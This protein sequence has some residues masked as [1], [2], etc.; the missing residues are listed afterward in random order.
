MPIDS[1]I[2]MGVKPLELPDP[3]NAM[4]RVLQVQ[5][6]QGQN[7]LSRYSLA[8]AQRADDET[9]RLAQLL[10]GGGV[11]LSTPEGQAKAFQTAPTVAPGMI[12][13]FM[14][15]KKMT[16][17]IGKNTAQA[18]EFDAKATDAALG[19]F[20]SQLANV[21][22]PQQAAQWVQAQYAH[23]LVGKVMQ[24]LGPLDQAIARIPSDPAQ[25]ETWK[26]QNALGMAKFIELNAPK[27]NVVNTGAAQNIVQTPGLGGAPTI[28]GSLPNTVSPD[29]KLRADTSIQTTGMANATSRANNRDTI[30]S[31]NL[32]MGV[33]PGG[34]L[35]DNAERTAQAIA[36][37]QLPA[38]TGMALL[39]PKNQRILGRVMEINPQYDA[40]TVSAKK[41]AAS[42][43]TSGT[44]GNSLRSF[45]VAGQHLDQLGALADAMNNGNLQLVNQLGNT[46]A[47]QT[48][49]PAPTNFNAAKDIVSKEVMKAIVAGG[50]GVAEREEL[51]KTMSAANSPA[52]LKGVIQQYRNLMAAQHDALLQQRD[53]AGL[54]RSTLPNYSVG[55]DGGAAGGAG[56][57]AAPAGWSYVGPVK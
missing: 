21:Q 2:A 10:Q 15:G 6:A 14:E 39:N 48:G 57:P 44:L 20:R 51:N 16:S 22:N 7:D 9:N 40:T 43:F 53:A 49:S 12:K 47:A 38:P 18:G 31:E 33:T 45:A 25:F 37:G 52:Q 32:R 50:G 29:A 42:D 41:K 36:N 1:S 26:Q 34:G 46:I 3:L 11:D 28:A 4:A 8:K 23:P 30:A 24:S 5:A 27:T 17:E 55:N 19:Q 35:D 13:N 56:A 54:P